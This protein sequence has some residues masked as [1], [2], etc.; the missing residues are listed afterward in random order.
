MCPLAAALPLLLHA[1][2]QQPGEGQG[3]AGP[4]E[5]GSAGA[6]LPAA[7]PAVAV[8]QEAGPVELPGHPSQS[9]GE[10]PAAAQGDPEAHAQRPRR[11]PAPG[12][13]GERSRMPHLN[14]LAPSV[15]GSGA[16]LK[17]RVAFLSAPDAD[18]SERGGG[19]Q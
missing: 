1:I 17:R 5:A 18:G 11:P 2:L 19:H 12:R 13:C 14:R 9:S 16:G 8:Q 10:V 4:E 15:V 6:G 7:L 3:P